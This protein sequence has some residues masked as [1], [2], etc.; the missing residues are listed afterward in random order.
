MKAYKKIFHLMNTLIEKGMWEKLENGKILGVEMPKSKKKYYASV[1][2]HF[3]P[4]P[5]IM[6]F[7]GQKGILNLRD[8]FKVEE[9]PFDLIPRLNF[10]GVFFEAEEEFLT[11][12]DLSIQEYNPYGDY[13]GLGFP[14]L[15]RKNDGELEKPIDDKDI[16]IIQIV[17]EQLVEDSLRKLQSVD[18]FSEETRITVRKKKGN[19][20]KRSIEKVRVSYD[21]LRVNEMQ[22][23][24]LK[25]QS[26]KFF[27]TWHLGLL[28]HM[29]P[30]YKEENSDELIYPRGIFILD[31]EESLVNNS[32]HEGADLFIEATKNLI[33]ETINDLK[34]RPIKIITDEEAIYYIFKD[35]F[36]A[37]EI[38]I[39]Y[40]PYDKILHEFKAF[41]YEGMEDYD[42]ELDLGMEDLFYTFLESKGIL[43][44]NFD[45]LDKNELDKIMKEFQEIIFDI[46]ETIEKS[47]DDGK[48][49]EGEEHRDIIKGFFL[50]GLSKDHEED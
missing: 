46:T 16:K 11:P 50:D 27:Q 15:F 4:E 6:I 40:D 7:E 24:P 41:N 29:E 44:N 9:E 10:L 36:K 48:V 49:I 25:K 28:Y 3:T 12:F 21:P 39:L 14:R 23:Y 37:L 20:W 32:I 1:I 38:E 33:E 47:I 31:A 17:L 19:I 43:P 8:L 30:V 42:D 22:V 13:D 35:Y 26:T 34:V 45:D 5:S 18:L 2:S